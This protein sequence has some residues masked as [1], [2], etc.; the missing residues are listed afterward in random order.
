MT[1]PALWQ[2]Y[3]FRGHEVV[4]VQQW[5]DSFGRRMVRI[6]AA[7]PDAGEAGSDDTGVGLP[8]DAF[9]AEAEPRPE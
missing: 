9:L 4:V 5:S 1:G 7:A 2:R 8:E 3:R 6:V